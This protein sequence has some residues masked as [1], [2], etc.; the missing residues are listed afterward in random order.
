M[1]LDSLYLSEGRLCHASENRVNNINM[2]EVYHAIRGNLDFVK[3][4][5]RR[6][7]TIATLGRQAPDQPVR[8]FCQD[9]VWSW[10]C[11]YPSS[12]G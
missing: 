4:C 5:P 8:V 7:G 9:E 3:Q 2:L 1:T 10:A 12:V 6:L 11:T